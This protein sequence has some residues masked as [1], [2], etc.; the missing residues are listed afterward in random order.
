[1]GLSKPPDLRTDGQIGLAAVGVTVLASIGLIAHGTGLAKTLGDPDDAMR[2][3]LVRDLMAGRG[4]F[5]QLIIRLQPPTGIV[6]H[7]SRLLDG[8]LA[9]W[10]SAFETVLPPEQAEMAMRLLWPLFLILPATV[11]ALV[12]SRRLGGSLAAF[13]C[14]VLLTSNQQAFEEFVPGRIDH[15]NIQIVMILIAAACAMAKDDRSRWALVA[16]GATAFGLAIGLE[17]LP[18]HLL[19]GV[20]YAVLAATGNDEG[21]T[22]RNYALS[23]AAGILVFYGLQTP[24]GR[25][26]MS[27]CDAIGLNLVVAVA[28]M[29]SGLIAITTKRIQGSSRARLVVLIA[30]AGAAIAAYLA[31]D[32]ACVDGPLA[33]VDP[34][35][36]PFW[37]NIVD[38]M[39]P[40]PVIFQ[41]YRDLGISLVWLSCLMIAAVIFI[42]VRDWP[43]P[44]AAILLVSTLVLLAMIAGLEAF[45]MEN[46]VFW[47]GFPLLATAFSA[48]AARFW[49]GL[50]LPTV[51]FCVLL[52]P[53]SARGV[54]IA[55]NA[56]LES[57]RNPLPEPTRSRCHDTAEYH[58]LS[59]LPPGLVLADI[60]MGPFILANTHD[61]VLNAPYHRMASSILASHGALAA[62]TVDAERKFRSLKVDYLAEC[63]SSPVHPESGS[64]EWDLDHER[65]PDW[66]QPLSEKGSA[67]QIYRLRKRLNAIP[68][69]PSHGPV[70]AGQ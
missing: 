4:W 59:S 8:A 58:Q 54:F 69:S 57:S 52:S 35:I 28:I 55:A 24:P 46:Y 12:I 60:S 19:I 63:P 53:V 50:M 5:D 39:Q 64:I 20:S 1:V 3:V 10:T 18:F 16:G 22:T 9:L 33:A 43:R 31:L 45:R 41:R 37:F 34:R 42:L 7:W 47:L 25:W 66:L 68:R 61:N 2:L 26:S 27:F 21:I 44:Q 15:H 17:A 49:H 67:L 14:A 6:L 56:A 13:T 65:I 11:C 38:E 48:M 40:L 32:T 29:S 23:L 62:K 30:A 70:A 36:R 51:V